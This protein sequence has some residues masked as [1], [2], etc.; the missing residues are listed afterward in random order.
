MEPLASWILW[1]FNLDIIPCNLSFQVLMKII[2]TFAEWINFPKL[3][4]TLYR[5]VSLFHK[6]MFYYTVCISGITDYASKYHSKYIFNAQ[7]NLFWSKKVHGTFSRGSWN[8][9]NN[10][11]ITPVVPWNFMELKQQNLKFHGIP[12]NFVHVQS[13]R[14]FQGT[15]FSIFPISMEFHGTF[16][17]PLKIPWNSMERFWS[18][19]GFHVIPWK[20]INLIFKKIIFLNSADG[21]WLIIRCYFPVSGKTAQG[22]R[23]WR[24]DIYICVC[25]YYF[26]AV[27][28]LRCQRQLYTLNLVDFYN[29]AEF[30]HDLRFRKVL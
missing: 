7:W 18:S 9:L 22:Q 12:W 30:V 23:K 11:W 19:M 5:F 6:L 26:S 21:I 24:A 13:S 14:E 2:S 25:V 29:F 20:L 8:F 16:D 15:F 3:I 10:I 28:I 1:V 17:F 4:C 27:H